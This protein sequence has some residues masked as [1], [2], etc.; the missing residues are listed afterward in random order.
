MKLY[1]R[2]IIF[3]FAGIVIGLPLDA[4]HVINGV[5]RYKNP[6]LGLQ[7]WWVPFIYA[8]GGILLCVSHNQLKLLLKDKFRGELDTKIVIAS[9]FPLLIT[10]SSSGYIKNV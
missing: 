3:A 6:V 5:L 1:Q 10:Y 7:T 2:I 9:L 4:L 8:M